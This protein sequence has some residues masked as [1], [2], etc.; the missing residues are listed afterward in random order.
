MTT[1]FKTLAT[2]AVLLGSLGALGLGTLAPARPA[3]SAAP[4]AAPA[5]LGPRIV[6]LSPAP[7]AREVAA[8]V[9][10]SAPI[11]RIELRVD[12]RAVAVNAVHYDA[13]RQRVSYAA[14]ALAPG[15]HAARLTLWDRSGAYRWQE[16]T[17]TV[18]GNPALTGATDTARQFLDAFRR[19]DTAGMLRLMSPRLLERN[20]G[21]RVARMLGVQN[22]PRR[23]DVVS[24][25]QVG[26]SGRVEVVAELRFAQGSVAARLDVIP[27]AG[28]YRV[29]AI[30][31]PP[32]APT[33]KAT[34][35]IAVAPAAAM[36][37]ERVLVTGQGWPAGTRVGFSL[38]GVNMGA[39]G[40][41]GTATA[42][43]RG[44]FQAFVTLRALPSGQPIPTPSTVVVVAH[45]ADFRL[46][47]AAPIVAARPTVTVSPTSARAGTTV[48]LAGRGWPA[49]TRVVLSM[50]G[51][52]T[53]AGGTYGDAIADA[54]GR[55][56]LR[57]RL[58]ALPNGVPLPAGPVVLLLHNA[59]GSL[60]AAVPFTVTQ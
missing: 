47:A 26:P 8:Q 20:R 41:Y 15:Q 53:G 50:G 19:D 35:S 13:A 38:G 57:A 59:D 6:P 28:G 2:S 48:T 24:V 34:P 44:Q 52:A 45:S 9:T 51:T 18:A 3:N 14:S 49:G 7:H 55:V 5:P 56:T 29:D 1:R 43:G 39:S 32:A 25:G 37:G 42:D 40:D 11:T 23:I 12:G 31:P 22:T 16:W 60:K 30:A 10:A 46:T 36:P 4:P 58:S 54:Q 17:F 27:T 21:E 33:K